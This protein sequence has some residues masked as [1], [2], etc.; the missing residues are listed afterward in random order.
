MPSQT[1]F[2]E[3][4]STLALPVTNV[5]TM[6]VGVGVGASFA[7][8]FFCVEVKPLAQSAKTGSVDIDDL[9]AEF[10]S[11][12]SAHERAM[13]QGRQWVAETFYQ[14]RPHLAQLRLSKGWSQ[15]ELAQRASTSQSYVAR[16]ER[17]KIDPQI[18]TV[19]KIAEALGVSMETLAH[20]LLVEAQS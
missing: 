14:D 19:R 11:K 6:A 13:S 9:V 18:S 1:E 2:F 3:H 20:A 8:V 17:G 5:G 10:Q 4:T 7:P 12:S 15:L 16:L